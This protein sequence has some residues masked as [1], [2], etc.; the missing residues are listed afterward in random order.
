MDAAETLR[1]GATRTL[2]DRFVARV[3]GTDPVSFLD[4]TT[5]QDLSGLTPRSSALTC[6]LDEK[7]RIQAELRATVLSDGSVLLDA[8]QPARAAVVGWLARVAPLSGC[9]IIDES[10]RWSVTAVRGDVPETSDGLVVPV[11]WGPRG[12]DV[13]SVDGKQIDAPERT[14]ADHDAELVAY[15]R[16]RFGVDFDDTTHIAETPLITRAV[17]FTKGCYPGQ[18][19]VARV[20][21]LGR[22][23]KRLVGLDIARDAVPGAGTPLTVDG[24]DVGCI[25]S[26]A[27]WAGRVAAIGMLTSDV[28]DG[29]MVNV[30][31]AVATV[32][33]L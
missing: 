3:T 5:S 30:G 15:G 18:E 31:S 17:S 16:P 32:R 6:M 9:E 28:N 23:R 33:A 14:L 2:L 1:T 22:A 13:L 26:A 20:Q 12:F 7:G 24:N 10:D 19:S 8:E 25:T 21:N 27:R 29:E 4:A 11:E